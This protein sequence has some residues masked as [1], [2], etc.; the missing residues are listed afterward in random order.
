MH[1]HMY[2]YVYVC[3]SVHMRMY[4]LMYTRYNGPWSEVGAA[5]NGRLSVPRSVQG[6]GHE[7]CP[8]LRFAPR[9]RLYYPMAHYPAQCTPYL[10]APGLQVLYT[11]TR[12]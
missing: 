4:T 7:K 5:L 9:H 11:S 3:K 1:M 12:T 8:Q 6:Y 2:M 10:E